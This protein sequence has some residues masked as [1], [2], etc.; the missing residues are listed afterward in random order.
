MDTLLFILKFFSETD[1][2]S[3]TMQIHNQNFSKKKTINKFLYA[4]KWIC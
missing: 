1:S 3:N 4:K 2:F